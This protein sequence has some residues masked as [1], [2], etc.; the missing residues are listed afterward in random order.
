MPFNT[1]KRLNELNSKIVYRIISYSELNDKTD[2]TKRRRRRKWRKKNLTLK[3]PPTITAINPCTAIRGMK[4]AQRVFLIVFWTVLFRSIH[5][6]DHFVHSYNVFLFSSFF[7]FFSFIFFKF[8]FSFTS[9]FY[10]YNLLCVNTFTVSDKYTVCLAVYR[11]TGWNAPTIW[12][13]KHHATETAYEK[14]RKL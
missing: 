11:S 5:S 1:C 2:K 9:F 7:C 6:F 13:M 12:K 4:A 3:E 10:R 8:V 14:K